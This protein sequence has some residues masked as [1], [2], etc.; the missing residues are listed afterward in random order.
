MSKDEIK[1]MTVKQLRAQ[2]VSKGLPVG[3]KKA[4]LIQRLLDAFP[5]VIE[6]GTTRKWTEEDVGK[7]VIMRCSFGTE[8]LTTIEALPFTI[9]WA[10]RMTDDKGKEYLERGAWG[11]GEIIIGPLLE[12]GQKFA[13]AEC[14]FPVIQRMKDLQTQMEGFE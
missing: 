2:L 14:A 1:S 3:G 11:S 8:I 6:P 12:V 9:P 5:E 10:R 4:V 13:Q 7:K